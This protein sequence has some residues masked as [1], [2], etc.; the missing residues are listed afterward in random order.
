MS[1]A[2]FQEADRARAEHQESLFARRHVNA[3]GTGLRW[4]GGE[5][6]DELC[7]SVLVT[8]K[9]PFGYLP[10]SQVLPDYVTIDGTRCKVDVV[11]GGPFVGHG[12]PE[13]VP[14]GP[15]VT[16]SYRPLENGCEI[17]NVRSNGVGTLSCIVRDKNDNSLC[18]LSNNHVLV[19]DNSGDVGDEILQPRVG[20]DV[21]A[22]LKR[23]IQYPTGTATT[24]VDAA[25]A[26]LTDDSMSSALFADNRMAP[27]SQQHPAI[28]LYFAGD[29]VNGIGMIS[30]IEDIMYSLNIDMLDPAGVHA[31]TGDDLSGHIEKVGRTTGY[32]SSFIWATN[33]TTPVQMEKLDGSSVYYWFSSLI[34]TWRFG[35]PGDSG[36]LV[37]LGGDGETLLPIDVSSLQCEVLSSVGSMY[38]LPL[39]ADED[40][41]DRVRDEFLAQS[42]TGVLLTQTFYTN[43]HVIVART[44]NLEASDSE[45]SYAQALYMKYHDFL[46]SALNDPYDP[47]LVV[48][49]ENQEDAQFALFGM[50]PYLTEEE[51]TAITTL[52]IDVLGPTLGMTFQQLI[53][54]MNHAD[55]VQKVLDILA[56]V[57]TI[58]VP[59]P[60]SGAGS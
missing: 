16:G 39:P 1:S 7:V 50:R 5:L 22:H 12:T 47:E 44:E 38:D 15:T 27:I 52:F 11:Q 2:S 40:L 35:W 18:V 17:G 59:G 19:V 4:R 56:P 49:E 55:T 13:F 8:R 25:I 29:A 45:K 60:L 58:E 26:E 32:S 51:D 23:F 48:T 28:G 3:V 53:D 14:P 42:A 20:G 41:A 24:S 6:T 10:Q 46:I 54:Y 21:I 43:Q 36:S 31:V 37:C 9:R 34:A 57:P 30:R 33:F